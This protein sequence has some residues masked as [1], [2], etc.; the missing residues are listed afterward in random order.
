MVVRKG[1][2][3]SGEVEIVAKQT[4]RESIW[5]EAHGGMRRTAFENKIVEMVQELYNYTQSRLEDNYFVGEYLT[6]YRGVGEDTPIDGISRTLE[7]WTD[8]VG[9]AC[10]FAGKGGK[11]LRA[12]IRKENI[13]ACYG[14]LSRGL[15][16]VNN[17]EFEYLVINPKACQCEDMF[18][19]KVL[20]NKF[21]FVVNSFEYGEE[22]FLKWDDINSEDVV[23]TI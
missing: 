10:K 1:R 4:T 19:V 15:S 12:H 9:T 17:D 11:V 13:L 5:N 3:G 2:R 16:P 8:N 7:S 6:L 14:W 22:D 18:D 23:P 21:F 20:E